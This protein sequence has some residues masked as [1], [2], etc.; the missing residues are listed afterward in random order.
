MH[1]TRRQRW[2][3]FL[4]HEIVRRASVLSA[5]VGIGQLSVL[6]ATPLLTRLYSPEDFGVFGTLY[7][8]VV[9]VGVLGS[10]QLEADL[11]LCPETDVPTVLA[12]LC[13]LALITTVLLWFCTSA[14]FLSRIGIAFPDWASWSLPIAGFLQLANLPSAY[15]FVRH[16]R[17]TSYAVQR[18]LRLLGQTIGQLC[19]T[20]VVGGAPGLWLGFVF[21]QLLGLVAGWRIVGSYLPRLRAYHVGRCLPYLWVARRYPLYTLPTAVLATVLQHAPPLL[22]ASTFSPQE[23]GLLLLVQRLFG[24]PIRLLSHTTSQVLL[25]ELRTETPD[26]VRRR[27]VATLR[28]F[29]LLGA[30]LCLL[31]IA[32]GPAGWRLLLGADWEAAWYVFLC[33]IPLHLSTFAIDSIRSIFLVVDDRLYLLHCLWSVVGLFASFLLATSAGVSFTTIVSAFS[34]LSAVGAGISIGLLFATLRRR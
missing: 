20:F 10:L 29:F 24:L 32:P 12:T 18:M 7:A 1:A 9:L 5:G 14:G 17:F 27:M 30:G 34:I 28:V 26:L 22:A 21:G 31:G 4:R 3:S 23:G 6:L 13:S 15:L 25:S 19:S 16:R 8:V 2:P 11:A 33:T